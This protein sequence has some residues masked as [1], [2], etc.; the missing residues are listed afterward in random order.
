[1][2]M[3]KIVKTFPSTSAIEA[4][5]LVTLANTGEVS[6]A[7]DE[8]AP[9][10][11]VTEFGG[12]EAG[13]NLSIA[14]AGPSIM[15]ELGEALSAGDYVTAGADGKAKAAVMG[16]YKAGRILESGI[17]GDLV[18]IMLQDALHDVPA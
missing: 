18:Q 8:L 15:V 5:R 11:G 13:D 3:L 7:P 17:D 10:F 2:T 4:N 6:T 1:M 9:I 16:K 12:T 14:I